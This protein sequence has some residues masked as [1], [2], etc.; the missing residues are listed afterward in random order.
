[1]TQE[2]NFEHKILSKDDDFSFEVFYENA[3]SP[4]LLI[5]EHA[6]NLF[7][8]KLNNLGLNE[9]QRL[10]HIAWDIG[11]KKLALTMSSKL[12]ATLIAARY[13]RLVYDCNRSPEASDAMPFDTE[14][15][16]VPGNKDISSEERSARISEIYQPFQQKISDVITNRNE[17]VLVTVHSFTP[18]FYGKKREISIGFICGDDDRITSE[19]LRLCSDIKFECGKNVPYGPS[20]GVLHTILKHGEANQIPCVMIEVRNDLLTSDE[21]INQ[22]SDILATRLIASLNSIN[23]SNSMKMN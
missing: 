9:E 20:D 12:D 11:A 5:C 7:P 17:T 4:F 23:N 21:S 1:M 22:I 3:L 13:S 19:M 10:S 6:S 16:K 2:Y 18:V 8:E 15:C 14:V